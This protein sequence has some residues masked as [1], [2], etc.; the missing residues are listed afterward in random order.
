[1]NKNKKL[2][3]LIIT[4]IL[5]LGL[6][7]IFSIKIYNKYYNWNL[8]K[9]YFKQDK[10]KQEIENWMSIRIIENKFNINFENKL[11]LNLSFYDKS[12]TL[13][14]I[15]TEKKLDCKEIIKKLNTK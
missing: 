13:S 10:S 6:I 11:N 12:K 2:F 1:M 14:T 15:C 8:H 3:L 5:I 7:S 4:L 9:D